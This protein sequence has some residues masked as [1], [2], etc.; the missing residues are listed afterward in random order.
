RV[1]LVDIICKYR[2]GYPPYGIDQKKYGYDSFSR[3][4]AARVS[5]SIA[6][7]APEIKLVPAPSA[8]SATTNPM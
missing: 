4:P 3:L 5:K 6:K 8:I 7:S 1:I 2:G